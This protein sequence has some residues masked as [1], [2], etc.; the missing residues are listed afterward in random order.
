[1]CD[2]KSKPRPSYVGP[3]FCGGDAGPVRCVP[4]ARA[5]VCQKLSFSATL[6]TSLQ[7]PSSFSQLEQISSGVQSPLSEGMCFYHLKVLK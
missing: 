3:A 5:E 7:D 2:F 4:A 1:M 6:F